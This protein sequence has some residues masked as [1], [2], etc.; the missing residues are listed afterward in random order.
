M[1]WAGCCCTPITAITSA[2][3]IDHRNN[4]HL[5]YR[6]LEYS[7]GMYLL[8]TAG[9]YISAATGL[10]RTQMRCRSD[11]RPQIF[12]PRALREGLAPD[13]NRFPCRLH[14]SCSD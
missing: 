7:N 1:K 11:A 4:V 10:A 5:I 8:G 9:R 6:D 13:Y 12:T 2:N 3:T 14:P